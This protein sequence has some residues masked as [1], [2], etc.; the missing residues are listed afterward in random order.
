[1]KNWL[2]IALICGI[3]ATIALL[4]GARPEL[5]DSLT[6]LVSPFER[7]PYAVLHDA[8]TSHFNEDGSLS[9]EFDAVTLKHFRADTQKSSDEDYMLITAPKLTLY[10]DPKPW[11]VTAK[12]GK[13]MQ[14]GGKLTLWDDVRVWQA[15]NTN[16]NSTTELITDNLNIYPEL[17][18]IE[19]D[20]HVHVISPSGTVDADGLEIDMLTQRIKLLANVRG[21]HEPIK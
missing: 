21:H 16:S 15:P 20:A 4:W 8:K 3:T 9:Y 17:K 6:K 7:F 12:Q 1:M 5:L 13:V 10:G 2:Y 18:R 19:T 14:Q 11:H